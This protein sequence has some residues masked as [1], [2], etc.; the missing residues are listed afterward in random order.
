MDGRRVEMGPGEVS[1]GGD[2]HCV[3]DERGHTGH[4][5]GTV[6]DEPAVLMLV[7]LEQA[8]ARGRPA[9]LLD[10]GDG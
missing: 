6:G 9:N 10:E 5:S 1:F 7:Q 8:G 2:Q 4:R 3:T